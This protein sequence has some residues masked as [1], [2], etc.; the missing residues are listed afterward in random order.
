MSAFNG[1]AAAAL[2]SELTARFQSLASMACLPSIQLGSLLS[3][4][5]SAPRLARAASGSAYVSATT[6]SFQFFMNSSV[7]TAPLRLEG[8][9]S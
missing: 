5:S 9:P 6:I 7:A 8:P 1:S 2:D 4:G 3:L